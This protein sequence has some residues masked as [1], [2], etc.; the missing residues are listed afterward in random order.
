MTKTSAPRSD[1]VK[2][3]VVSIFYFKSQSA[4]TGSVFKKYTD[5]DIHLYTV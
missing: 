4:L 2:E 1:I 5:L 3:K